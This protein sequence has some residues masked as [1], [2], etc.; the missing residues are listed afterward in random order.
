M[1]AIDRRTFLACTSAGLGLAALHRPVWSA[2]Q[3]DTLRVLIGFAPGGTSDTVGRRVGHHLTGNY[4]KTVIVE[5]RAGA[6]G[7]IAIQ[8]L[9]G[10]PADGSAML[11]TPASMLMIYPHIY[12]KLS[13]EPLVDVTPLSL[14]C[15]LDFALAV[16]PSVP[17]EVKDVRGFHAWVKANPGQ[18][19]FGSPAPG[20]VP[21]FL[22][23]LMARAGDVS[24]THVAYRGSQPAVLDLIGGQIPCVSAPLGEF[25]QH[26]PTGKIR[27]LATSG[28]S[29]SRFAPDVPTYAEQGFPDLIINEWFG[30]F[31]PPAMPDAA[32]QS[33]NAALREA[34][35]AKDV[36]DGLATMGLE[37]QSSTS[38]ELRE[39]LKRDH[40]SWAGIVKQ[41]GFKAD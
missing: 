34:L 27:L 22:G 12:S 8:G 36:V 38:A 1:T 4:A 17:A 3:Q 33:L 18:G 25:I 24:M 29:R 20:S 31:G 19:S 23:E 26:L 15:T 2:T 11:M 32:V 7:Q 30:F 16:G 35:Q 37:A 13:Y 28:A 10:M 21:H 41:V 9:K 5:N 14:A 40:D 6:G 39:R